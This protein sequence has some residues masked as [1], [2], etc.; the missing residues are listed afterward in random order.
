MSNLANARAF[1][2][3]V[4]IALAAVLAGCGG[5]DA[6]VLADLGSGLTL[7]ADGSVRGA[8]PLPA[9]NGYEG[10]MMGEHAGR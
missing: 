8:G 2:F 5:D 4:A 1:R 3:T 6:D 7:M 9:D 10:R